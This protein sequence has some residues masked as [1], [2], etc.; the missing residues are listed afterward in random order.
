M[1]PQVR[2][3][4]TTQQEQVAGTAT[5]VDGYTAHNTHVVFEKLQERG[6]IPA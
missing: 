3:I 5:E 2:G 1:N 4:G 6:K